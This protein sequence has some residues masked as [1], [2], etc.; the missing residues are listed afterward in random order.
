MTAAPGESP[1][2]Q[3]ANNLSTLSMKVSFRFGRESYKFPFVYDNPNVAN[4]S[5]RAGTT[6]FFFISHLLINYTECVLRR[7]LF[8]TVQAYAKAHLEGAPV[9]SPLRENATAAKYEG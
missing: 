9:D 1:L 5:R 7:I 8:T 4:A 2:L 6:C 3:G